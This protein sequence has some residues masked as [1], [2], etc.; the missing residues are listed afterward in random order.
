M[1]RGGV[2]ESGK[3]VNILH[4]VHIF[5]DGNKGAGGI[6]CD[7]Y[8]NANTINRFSFKTDE[9]GKEYV[10]LYSEN[11]GFHLKSDSIAFF[12]QFAN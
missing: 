11:R 12:R 7:Y 4:F 6:E 10:E 2:H 3:G 1:R 9:N 8:I 5:F